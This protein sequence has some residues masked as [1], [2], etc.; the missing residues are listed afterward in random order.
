MTSMDLEF[1]S[2]FLYSKMYIAYGYVYNKLFV[3]PFAIVVLINFIFF[4]MS[5]KILFLYNKTNA[6]IV[7]YYLNKDLISIYFKF[8]RY[9]KKCLTCY[10]YH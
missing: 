5:S 7:N 3:L 9:I 10:F 8:F 6:I 2:N 4:V 1:I